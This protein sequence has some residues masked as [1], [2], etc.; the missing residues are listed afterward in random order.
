M[1]VGA[2]RLLLPEMGFADVFSLRNGQLHEGSSLP[3]ASGASRTKLIHILGSRK[4]NT[5]LPRCSDLLLP[6][7]TTGYHSL[8]VNSPLTSATF[9]LSPTR[10]SSAPDG[11]H[12]VSFPPSNRKRRPRDQTST[13]APSV[14]TAP[15]SRRSL[16][17]S[18][19]MC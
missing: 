7:L 17:K 12:G 11:P 10:T 4:G 3:I 1:M 19:R 16:R 2:H 5:S 6:I 18:A 13:S 9:Y 15:R 8:V 14:N